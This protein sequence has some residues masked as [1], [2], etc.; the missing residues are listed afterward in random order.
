MATDSC[1]SPFFAWEKMHKN[2]RVS[3]KCSSFLLY[4]IS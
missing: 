3:Q 1:V 4:T 2:T